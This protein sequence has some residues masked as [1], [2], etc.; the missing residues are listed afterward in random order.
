MAMQSS[1]LG[2][3]NENTF[4][5]LPIAAAARN[6]NQN[7]IPARGLRRNSVLFESVGHAKSREGLE[8]AVLFSFFV[9]TRALHPVLIDASKGEE[10]GDHDDG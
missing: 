2:G 6:Q 3:Y 10:E 4:A 8:R 1:S 7:G 5:D 9:L